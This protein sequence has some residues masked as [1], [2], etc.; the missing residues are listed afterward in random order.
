[1]DVEERLFGDEAIDLLHEHI[2]EFV[3]TDERVV[4]HLTCGWSRPMMTSS[5]L[6]LRGT[7]LRHLRHDH[8]GS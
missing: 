8:E 7:M 1:M 6:A 5:V 3:V 4:I 2:E